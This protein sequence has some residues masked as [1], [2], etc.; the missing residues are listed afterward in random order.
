MMRNRFPEKSAA[1]AI[2]AQATV[3][4][5]ADPATKPAIPRHA[6]MELTS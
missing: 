5:N 4:A 6:I 2:G 1:C 3:N